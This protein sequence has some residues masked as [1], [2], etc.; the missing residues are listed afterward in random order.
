M[1]WVK[2]E[3]GDDESTEVEL[4][5]IIDSAKQRDFN[6][7]EGKKDPG[8]Q[9]GVNTHLGGGKGET[10]HEDL[11]SSEAKVLGGAVEENMDAVAVGVA[12]ESTVVKERAVVEE[13]G[14]AER[15]GVTEEKVKIDGEA[16]VSVVKNTLVDVYDTGKKMK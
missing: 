4:G 1:V 14:V 15:K 9:Q 6:D 2:E 13:R 8:D 11:E 16:I 10:G 5:A 3:T 12:K 7:S